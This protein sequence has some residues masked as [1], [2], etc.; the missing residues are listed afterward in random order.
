MILSMFVKGKVDFKH[1]QMW[2]WIYLLKEKLTLDIIKYDFDYIQSWKK[3]L[4]LDMTKY[5]F[6]YVYQEKNLTIDMTKLFKFTAIH[7][8]L[9]VGIQK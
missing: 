2:H 4:T 5:E 9:K 1:V 6:E 7:N 8:F 3:N